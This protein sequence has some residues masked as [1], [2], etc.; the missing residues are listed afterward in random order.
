MASS[1][2]QSVHVQNDFSNVGRFQYFV[3]PY[4]RPDFLS[5]RLP[6]GKFLVKHDRGL[7]K[8]KLNNVDWQAFVRV[9][10]F[11]WFGLAVQLEPP[12]ELKQGKDA[13][14]ET[15]NV[16]GE[17]FWVNQSLDQVPP[18]KKV[19]IVEPEWLHRPLSP[20]SLCKFINGHVGFGLARVIASPILKVY[21]QTS[22]A[23]AAFYRC[24]LHEIFIEAI[25]PSTLDIVLYERIW[26][27]VLK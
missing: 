25:V 21:K 26:A 1:L 11:K 22:Q 17:T 14:T 7:D 24:G 13:A 12:F 4:T 5:V 16:L 15:V 10:V 8:I 20:L 23:H 18:A 2:I 9:M 6:S 3:V 27:H 19:S